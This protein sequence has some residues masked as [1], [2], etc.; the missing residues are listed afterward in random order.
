M[1]TQ[2]TGSTGPTTQ[3]IEESA[4]EPTTSAEGGEESPAEELSLD[5][6]FE[7][8]KNERRREVIR[9]LREHEQQVTLSDLAEH[10]AALENDTDIASITS[11]QR[12]RVYVG[13]YQCHLPKMA[14]MGIVQFNQN[15]GIVS[16]GENAP[17]LYEYLDN[18]SPDT[19]PWHE[20]YLGL[21]G[22]GAALFFV[23]LVAGGAASIAALGVLV[24][25]VGGCSALHAIEV[26][27][28]TGD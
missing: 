17:Q 7:I 15:R 28:E 21:S 25:A 26:G 8:L 6:I 23:S 13:L 20:Y 3:Q 16:L 5:L 22:V 14:D 4:T 10:I 18:Q 11:S 27:A 19:R 9:Y 12:K 1:S 24:L 2:E